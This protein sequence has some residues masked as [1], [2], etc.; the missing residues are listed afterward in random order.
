MKKLMVGNWKMNQSGAEINAFFDTFDEKFT[1]KRDA[2]IAS[3]A[4]QFIFV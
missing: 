4:M 1:G 3:Q 2:W